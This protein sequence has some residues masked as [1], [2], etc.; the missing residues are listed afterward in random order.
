MHLFFL[1]LVEQSVLCA[2]QHCFAVCLQLSIFIFNFPLC[3]GKGCCLLY[4]VVCSAQ[5]S[6]GIFLLC[7]K[8]GGR[9]GAVCYSFAVT[10]FYV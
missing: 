8:G 7:I 2:V 10:F 1:L 3:K 6:L 9:G 5:S 4:A